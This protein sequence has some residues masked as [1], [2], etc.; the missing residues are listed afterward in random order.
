MERGTL[1]WGP[2][3]TLAAAAGTLAGALS[4]EGIISGDHSGSFAQ[5]HGW[6]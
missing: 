1:R 6:E 4:F 5:R 3:D 2:K